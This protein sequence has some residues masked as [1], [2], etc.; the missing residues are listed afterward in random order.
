MVLAAI[1]L[2]AQQLPLIAVGLFF[3]I[4]GILMVRYVETRTTIMTSDGTITIE[5]KRMIGDKR[6]I[7]RLDR[8]DIRSLDY[9]KG[10]D[11]E[12]NVLSERWCTLYLNVIFDEQI[13]IAKRFWFGWY[14]NRFGIP[15]Y[16][17]NVPLDTEATEIGNLLGISIK[18]VSYVKVRD[19]LNSMY[20]PRDKMAPLMQR[21]TQAQLDHERDG[22]SNSYPVQ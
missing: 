9:V 19:T 13:E 3:T 17:R 12:H 2:F 21:P 22:R 11:G 18:T 20:V 7:R 10:F 8:T 6:W 4:F 15:S 1:G 5:Y 16:K 14:I